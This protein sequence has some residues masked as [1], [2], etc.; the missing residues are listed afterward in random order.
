MSNTLEETH[1]LLC[2]SIYLKKG[3]RG[4]N[5]PLAKTIH[6]VADMTEV[7]ALCDITVRWFVFFCV[8][9]SFTLLWDLFI[10]YNYCTFLK[11]TLLYDDNK[12]IIGFSNHWASLVKMSPPPSGTSPPLHAWHLN[13]RFHLGDRFNFLWLS[14]PLPLPTIRFF[15]TQFR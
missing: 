13:P 6:G 5:K 8:F 11:S 3:L 4:Q 10:G 12:L 9:I 15:H 2:L 7:E 14:H 1:T